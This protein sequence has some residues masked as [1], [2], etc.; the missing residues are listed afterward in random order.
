M[1]TASLERSPFLFPLFLVGNTKISGKIGEIGLVPPLLV[2]KNTY[3]LKKLESLLVHLA[4][5]IQRNGYDIVNPGRNQK[6]YRI[7]R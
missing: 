3:L 1:S 5:I 4:L 2:K 7:I 6:I